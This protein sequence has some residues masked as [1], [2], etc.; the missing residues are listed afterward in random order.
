MDSIIRK[1]RELL[2]DGNNLTRED[3]QNI[4]NRNVEKK[5]AYQSGKTIR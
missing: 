3:I 2:Y 4:V 1:I 5:Q